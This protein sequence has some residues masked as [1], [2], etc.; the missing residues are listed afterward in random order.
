MILFF[1]LYLEKNYSVSLYTIAYQIL[2]NRFIFLK[3]M[4]CIMEKKEKGRR[5]ENERK[6]GEEGRK[7]E[8]EREAREGK[9]RR[10]DINRE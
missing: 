4:L 2:S 6:K 3:T 1:E 10:R 9:E 7:K 8:K 5:K